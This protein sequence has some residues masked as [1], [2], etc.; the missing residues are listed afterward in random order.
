L[1]RPLKALE[2]T[3]QRMTAG[4]LSVRTGI[5]RAPSELHQLAHAFDKMAESLQAQRTQN[6][7]LQLELEDRVKQRTAELENSNKELEAFSYSVSHDLR[8]PLR[9]VHG[10]V[11]RL[12]DQAPASLGPEERRLLNLISDAAKRMGVLIDDLLAFSRMGRVEL[13]RSRVNLDELVREVIAEVGRDTDQR[14]VD[15]SVAPLPVVHGD[16]ALLK[17][18]WFN[19]L[20]NAVKYTRNRDQA[21]ISISVQQERDE[22]TFQVRDNGAGFDNRYGHKLF[23]VFERLHRPEEFE[24][25]GIG[26]ANVRRVVARHGGRTWAEGELNVGASFFFTLPVPTSSGPATGDDIPQP[27]NAKADRSSRDPAS[28]LG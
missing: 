11:G 25:T 21:K 15:W 22:F 13:T 1:L 14:M 3:T 5:E 9:H 20:S 8:A 10:H 27:K 18:V 6:E 28:S 12:L 2:Y 4:D 17:Q 16:R 7:R 26:L 19:L 23:R 24:G